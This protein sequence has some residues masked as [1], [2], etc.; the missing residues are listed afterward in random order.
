MAGGVKLHIKLKERAV[1]RS[2]VYE[3]LK[4]I[5][6]TDITDRIVKDRIRVHEGEPIDFGELTRL[7]VT[8]EDMYREKGYRF[9]EIKYRLEEV[10][11]GEQR[12]TYS[13]DEGDR[14][15]IR[16][17]TFKGNSVYGDWRLRWSMRKT[18]QTNLISR[19]LKHDIY[20]PATAREDLDKVRDLYRSVGYKNVIVSDPE[21]VVKALNPNAV[22]TKDKK[23]RLFLTVPIEEGQRYKF[24]DIS[25]EG[26]KYTDEQLLRPSG[27]TAAAGCVRRS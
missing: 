15:R 2:I 7:K 5:G 9:A 26:N 25:I 16:K 4:R 19:F 22:N 3:G 27:A 6:N 17:I 21:I 12:V 14:V 1:L 20:N 13:V 10:T 11:P 23:R 24:G 18:A 8:L